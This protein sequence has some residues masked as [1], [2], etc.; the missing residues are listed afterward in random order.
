M[1]KHTIHSY[2]S[3]RFLPHEES[4]LLSQMFHIIGNG[5]QYAFYKRYFDSLADKAKFENQDWFI[6]TVNGYYDLAIYNW[7]M[8]FGAYSEPTHYTKLID[9]HIVLSF[10]YKILSKENID[11]KDLLKHLLDTIELKEEE[12]S[13]VHR[14]IKDYRD[15]YLVHRE[16]HPSNISDNCLHNPELGMI[17]KTLESL[18]LLL[19]KVMSY[20]PEDPHE[21]NVYHVQYLDVNSQ[22]DIEKFLELTLPNIEDA[23]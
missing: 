13:D 23:I 8:I 20:F 3:R 5:I 11:K 17:K 19:V 14:K 2:L 21:D 10:L 15:R 9:N 22:E 1:T 16:H 18:Y 6:Y 12:Y 7:N 4:R